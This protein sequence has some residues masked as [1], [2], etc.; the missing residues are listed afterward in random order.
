MGEFGDELAALL[1]RIE[2]QLDLAL[3]VAAGGAFA[4][5][6]FEAQHAAFVARAPR[7]DALA[8]PHF[9]LRQKLVEL[10]VRH[11][12]V[13]QDLFFLGLI[14]AEVARAGEQPA[15]VEFDDAR[16]HAVEETPVVGD[17]DDARRRADQEL[18]QPLDGADVEVVGRLI[19]Q[20]QV[21]RHRQRL[22]EREALL[23]PAGECADA[24]V[25][26]ERKALDD[27]L[28]L[29]F[30]GPRL[31]RL[32]LALQR[33]QAVEQRR[34]VGAGLG[35]GVRHGVVLGQ[36]R[37]N[38]AHPGDHGLEH[39]K[40][41]IEGRLLRHVAHADARLA[42]DAA[43]VERALPRQSPQQR[44]FTATVAPDQGHT[45]A[46]VELE[47]GMVEQRNVAEGQRGVGEDEMRHGRSGQGMRKTRKRRAGAA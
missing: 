26:I 42:P 10:G 38:F 5:Q 3:P 29:R 28:G 44:G 13:V 12:L 30:E 31:A 15:A 14:G 27:A 17:E 2:R 7:F 16:R 45:L 35:H 47:F 22:R 21:G 1:A 33:V 11:C 40:L 43:V 6:L 41:R 25:R 24:C 34:L 32:Q 9:F 4:A 39:R 36:E 18:F 19:E 20:E 46:G 37:G 23:L 8:N